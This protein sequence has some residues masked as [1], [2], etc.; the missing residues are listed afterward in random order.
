[1]PRLIEEAAMTL[2]LQSLARALGGEVSGDQVLAPGPGHLPKDRSLSV[3]IDSTAP[4]GFLVNSFSGDDPIASRDYVREKTGLPAFKPNGRRNG[5]SNTSNV[6]ELAKGRVVATYRYTD[7][8]GKL[9]YEVLRYEPKTFRQRRPDGKGGWIWSVKGCQ[10]VPYRLS[11]L[12]KYPDASVFVTEGEKDADRVAL[13]GQCA[14]TVACGDWT[15]DCIRALAGRDVLIL[16]DNDEAGRKKAHDAAQALH[17]VAKTIRIVRL[18]GLP[19]K[20]DVSNWLDADPCNAAKFVDVCFDA[21]LWTPMASPP[22]QPELAQG[23]DNA[24]SSKGV[25]INDFHAYMPAH[26]Y[27]YTPTREMW[28]ASSVNAR[29][30]RIPILDANGKPILD[31][32]GNPKTIPPAAWLDQNRPVEQMTWAPGEPMLIRDRLV[33]DGGWI[34]RNG[35]TC[36]NLYRPPTIK[37]GDATRAGPWLD[38]IRRVFGDDAEHI[39]KW[40]A[41]R[42]QRPHEKINHALLLGG[43][44]G[45]GKDTLLEPVKHAVGPWNFHEISPQHMLGRFNGFARSVILRVNEARDLGDVERF[46]FYEHL[47]AY[48]AAPPDVLRVDEKNL[49]E[50][51]ILNCCGVIVTTNHK[52]DGIHL[53]ADDRRHYVAWSDLTKADFA[54]DYWNTLWKWYSHD[55]D[56]HVAAYLAELDI[57]AFDPKAPPPKTQA[58]WEIVD[59]SRAPEDDELAD[60]LD[61]LGSPNAVTLDQVAAQAS[62][63]FAEWLRDRK[64]ARRVPHRFE[65]CRY[66]AVRNPNDTEGRWKISGRRHTIYAKTALPERDRIAA[67][68]RLAGTR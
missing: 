5:H 67:A 34:E 60:A 33:A 37:S 9:L 30:K 2:D 43:A 6:D 56:H 14:T 51:S 21:P 52:S 32:E 38:H 61:V 23:N 3:K 53:P 10:R 40:L 46:K 11:D 13:L 47:K 27:I 45:I 19:N 22:L 41:H 1:L 16:E 64:N 66:V 62:A 28:P 50:Y 35:V 54:D 18:P 42:V 7:N 31:K 57:S 24:P 48:T 68:F 4:D 26:S 65:A 59:A 20:G 25:S 17:G 29:I 49:R 15:E 8:S 58:F 12:L 55:G 44:Q 36:F 39:V 63:G